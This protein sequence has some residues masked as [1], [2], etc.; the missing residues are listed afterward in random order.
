VNQDRDAAGLF[1]EPRTNDGAAAAP[2]D[3]VDLLH[4]PGAASAPRQAA[5]DVPAV[6]PYRY[7]MTR[8]KVLIVDPSDHEIADVVSKSPLE[9][10]KRNPDA[11]PRRAAAVSDAGLL[12][13]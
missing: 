3:G 11:E 1:P 13:R 5:R 4:P 9:K 6:G 2:S 8:D 7:A 10:N 12:W